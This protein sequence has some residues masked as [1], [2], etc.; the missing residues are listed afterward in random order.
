MENYE[1]EIVF[2][3]DGSTDGSGDIIES[4]CEK[5]EHVKAVVYE[6][7]FGYSKTVFYCVQQA[8]GDAAIIV[9]CDMQ[10]PPEEIPNFV[11]KW[12]QGADVVLGVKSKSRENKLMYFIRTLGYCI[13]NLIFGMHIIPHA[14]EFELLDK[15][16]IEIL[17]GI[18]T[19]NPFLR[20][21]IL[22]YGKN[23]QKV[24]YTQDKRHKGKSH[25]NI[26]RYYDFALGGIV[27]MSDCIP[28]RF[29]LFAFLSSAAL[30]LETFIH[31]LP[32]CF[33]MDSSAIVTG[34]LIRFL[35]LALML[36]TMLVSMLFEY[37]LTI[38]KN[39]EQKP[40]IIEKK[41]INY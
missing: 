27:S 37:V 14:T 20:G 17:G 13:L 10:N 15:T 35:V 22:E 31:F 12:E 18:S 28:R 5:D 8:K 26:T 33:E 23:I 9:H 38:I 21:Y 34:I 24:Y 36:L 41:R 4:I 40:I 7:N 29:I 19:Q 1:Y 6:R 3:D 11:E 16:F 32:K 25:F 30:F 39:T 2:F